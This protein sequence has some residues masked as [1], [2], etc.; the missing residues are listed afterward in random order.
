MCKGRQ[1]FLLCAR[2][3][4]NIYAE[5]FYMERAFFYIMAVLN[6]LIGFRLLNGKPSPFGKGT[7]DKRK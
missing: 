3:T 2:G 4:Q 6:V 5:E 1:C 7:Y